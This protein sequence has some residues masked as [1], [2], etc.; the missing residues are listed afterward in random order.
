MI[1]EWVRKKQ[2][3]ITR[4]SFERVFQNPFFYESLTYNERER[5]IK[6]AIKFN[7]VLLS[8]AFFFALITVFLKFVLVRL[9]FEQT[10]VLLL[11]VVVFVLRSN[12]ESMNNSS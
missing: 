3:V 12:L 11:I 4:K 6:F 9:G 2:S 5:V 8:I 1:G 7:Q 10:V